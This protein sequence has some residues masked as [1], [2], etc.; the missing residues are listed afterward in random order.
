MI[1]SLRRRYKIVYATRVPPRPNRGSTF[2]FALEGLFG[3]SR[4]WSLDRTK[5]QRQERLGIVVVVL[6]SGHELWE[7]M[8]GVVIVVFV[9]V[10]VVVVVGAV[11]VD[12]VIVVVV[13]AFAIQ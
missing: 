1:W 10:A 11:F 3:D 2:G 9:V 6:Q 4:F 13:L 8:S 7:M 12:V 5:A